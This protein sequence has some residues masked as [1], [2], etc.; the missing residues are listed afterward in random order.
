MGSEKRKDGTALSKSRDDGSS[1]RLRLDVSPNQRRRPLSER[2]AKSSGLGPESFKLPTFSALANEQPAFPRGGASILTPLEK[3][4]IRAQA[5][6]DVLVE[7][8]RKKTRD[9]FDP[10]HG[11]ESLSDTQD[12]TLSKVGD[13]ATKS[14]LRKSSR[15]PRLQKAYA[16]ATPRIE[17]LSYKRLTAGSLILGRIAKVNARDLAVSLPNNLT[18]YVPL[19]AVSAQ[20]TEKVESL[21]SKDAE[22]VLGNEDTDDEENDIDLSRF[23]HSGQWVRVAV[24]STGEDA[25][26]GTVRTKRRIELSLDPALTNHGLAWK[27]LS[28]NCTLQASVISVEDHGVV[29][30]IGLHNVKAN[31]FIPGQEL[32]HGLENSQVKPGMVFLCLVTNLP[33]AGRV[34]RLS[35]KTDSLEK[36]D[37]SHALGTAPSINSF[38]PGTLVEILLSDVTGTGL[39]GKVMGMLDVTSDVVQSGARS[40]NASLG[41]LYKPGSKITGRLICTFPLSD[42]K[43][44]GFSILSHVMDADANAP[45]LDQQGADQH[46]LHI[47]SIIK[48][49][50]VVRVDPG[51]G[52]Y[53]KLGSD[54]LEGFAHVSRLSDFK[55]DAISADSGPY[56]LGT[57]HQARVLEYNAMDNLFLLSLQ[58]TVIQQ[59][60]LRVED[61]HVGEV[62]KGRV[63]KLITDE[64]GLKGII[65][66]LSERVTGLVPR[67]HL[68]DA[69]LQHPEKKFREGS[70]VSARVLSTDVVKRQVRLT[71]KK[72]L[73]NSDLKPWTTYSMIDAGASS[74]GTLVKV[75]SNG[76]VVQFYSSV[77]GFLPVS[78]M[79]EAYIK[80]AAQ[81][82]L[83]GQVLN[84]NCLHVDAE[85]SKLTLSCRDPAL[86]PSRQIL[87]D[88]V[89]G[90]IVDGMIFQ[91]SEDDLLL[92]L[93]DSDAPALLEV[94]HVSDGSSRKRHA[95][96]NKTRVGQ[97]LSGLLVLEVQVK[98]RLV[99]LCN[100]AS[101][102]RASKDGSLLHGVQDL[103]EGK[104]VTGFVSNITPDGIF[105]AFAAGLTGLLSKNQISAESLQLPDFGFTRLQTI[106]TT[107]SSIDYKGSQPRFWLSQKDDF[108]RTSKPNGTGSQTEVLIDAVDG[109]TASVDE[110]N[111]G[112]VTKARI[113]SVKDTQVNVE[114]ATNVLG[115][116]DVSEMFDKWEDIADRKKPLRAF[117]PKQVLPV[118]VLG[119]HDA[120]NHRFL[121]ISH[122]TGKTPLFELSAKPSIVKSND[123]ETLTL[124][125]VQVGSVWLTF[126]N[127]I[128]EDFLWLNI[129]PNVRGRIRAI[130]VSDDLSLL[131]DLGKNFP[132]GSALKAQVISVDVSKNH[133]DLTA[134]ATGAST[135]LTLKEIS[136]G[137]ILPGRVT[138]ASERQ[139]LV[140]LSD[141]IVGAVNLIDLSDDYAKADPTALRKNEIVRVCVVDVDVPNKRILLSV[142]PSKVLSSSLPV[143]DREITSIRQLHVND[144]IRG[145]VCNVADKG[146]FVT[147]GHGVTAFVRV[148]N[149][150]DSYIKEWR[151][152]FHRDQLV[153]GKIVSLDAESGHVQMSLKDSVLKPDYAAPTTLADLKVGQFVTGKVAKVEDFGVFIV[154]DSSANVRGLCHRSEIAEQRVEDAR[155]L[156]SEGDAVKAKVLK[157][158]HDTRRISFGLKASYF[159]NGLDADE[160]GEVNS[161]DGEDV[162]PGGVGLGKDSS[163][164]D[165]DGHESA[166]EDDKAGTD[167]EVSEDDENILG[168]REDGN[169]SSAHDNGG[170]ESEIEKSTESNLLAGLQVG[171]FDWQG[172]PAQPTSKPTSNPSFDTEP[173]PPKHKKKRKPAIQTDLTGDLDAQGPQSTDDYERLLL[174]Q[175]DSSLLWLQYMAFHLS[176]G[177][178]DTAR[179]IAQRALKTISPIGSG[180]SEAEK[181]NVWIALLNLENAYGDDET[182]ETI[183]RSACQVND[184]QKIHER[185]ASIFIQSSKHD[186]A[187]QLFQ[188]MLKKFGAEDPRIWLNYAT[189]LFDTLNDPERGRLLL[190]RA[191]QTLPAAAHIEVT[192]KFAAL[193]FRSASGLAER[194]RTIFEGLLDSFPKRVDLWNVLL[195]LETKYGGEGGDRRA[196][197]R[198]LFERIFDGDGV[199]GRQMKNKQARFFFK[200]WLEFEEREGDERSVERVKRRAEEWVVSKGK[201]KDSSFLHR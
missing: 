97:K 60:F 5:D 19:T 187:D 176:L 139:V 105:V 111:V 4:Q 88:T 75:Q 54:S 90:A 82:F 106:T 122:R 7:Q 137:M 72:S 6:S 41:D 121:P 46:T 173:T 146:V 184:P 191:L 102:L 165:N 160:A 156:F 108:A 27:D 150:S 172:L 103:R 61:V 142:R 140:Q 15:R 64:N 26:H 31:G 185:L 35:A 9:L 3:K 130:D 57:E 136:P 65:I 98:R 163:D 151:D 190:S 128:G 68:S 23:F 133:L 16:D 196:Q 166:D 177:E 183:F 109:S 87:Q 74:L 37:T 32:P 149:L 158:D 178:I 100:R 159:S 193:E 45:D 22:S 195:D 92:R 67:N 2:H 66:S 126:V 164:D 1:K 11:D 69:Q 86:V 18:G 147:L 134:K 80:D 199:N 58:E 179:K 13:E 175:P 104:K 118:R 51:L 12:G 182:T 40:T 127:N 154:V 81:H 99:R 73:V 53:F 120:R 29:V 52:L 155:K 201:E 76:A 95:A 59:P 101:L 14:R 84:V 123:A 85:N 169:T 43:R 192:S 143:E 71:L 91:K 167:D 107:I 113:T 152:E 131:A 10:K 38:L 79:S 153:K 93:A 49:A 44:L 138:K 141:N 144:V 34:V 117:S 62:V 24:T 148:T 20:F 25:A 119:A 17:G 56:K 70:T 21:L 132:V 28:T 188:T 135:Q 168:I 114:L 83:V 194:G 157:L 96:L 189:F 145:F 181:L 50:K 77:R 47:S 162:F 180:H 129:S 112:T 171:G 170:N 89:P 186:K 8:K 125:K 36:R 161:D 55:V 174:S 39:A 48:K 42:S 124:D 110:F 115:R 200:R 63:E 116:I 94:D 197:V 30:D 198:R 33:S 78:E